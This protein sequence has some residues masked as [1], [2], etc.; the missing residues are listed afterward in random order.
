LIGAE[1]RILIQI[2]I[3]LF[4]GRSGQGFVGETSVAEPALVEQQLF[5]GARA[6]DFWASSG[7]EYVNSYKKLQKALFFHT[8]I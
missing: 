5:A 3:F 8:K 1:D 6:E 7:S 4:K 2:L